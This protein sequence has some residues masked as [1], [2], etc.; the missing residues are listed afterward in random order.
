MKKYLLGNWLRGAFEAE[1]N[2][3]EEA[4]EWLSDRFL[5]S[6]PSEGGRHVLMYVYEPN[7]YGFTEKKLCKKDVTS[8]VKHPEEEVLARCKWSSI[9]NTCL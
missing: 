5:L 9:P 8:L 1:F 6:Y 7:E 2:S 3:L 4:W